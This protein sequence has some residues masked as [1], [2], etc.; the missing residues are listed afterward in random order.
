MQLYTIKIINTT[1]RILYI[2]NEFGKIVQDLEQERNKKK[3]KRKK[4]GKGIEREKK[5]DC[6]R[7]HY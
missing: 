6:E 7:S 4:N 2:I 1:N 3:K 5:K